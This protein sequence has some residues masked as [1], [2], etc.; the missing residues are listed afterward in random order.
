MTDRPAASRAPAGRALPRPGRDLAGAGAVGLAALVVFRLTLM[1]GPGFWDTAEAQTVPPILGTMHP[2]GFPAYVVAGWLASLLLTPVG[3]PAL[4]MN[5]F[6]ALLVAGAAAGAV[7]IARRI[8][9]PL[10][11][12]LAAGLGLALTPIAWKVA[13][14]ADAHPLHLAL[15]VLLVLLLLHWERGVADARAA[16]TP[17]AA[18]RRLVAAAAA[19]GV[20]AAN[21]SLALLVA[22]AVGLYVLATDPRVLLRPRSVLAAAGALVLVAGL[23][24]LQLPLRAGPFRAPLVYG[25]PETWDG[26][27]Y[28]VLAEQFRGSIVEPFANLDRKA[29]DLVA[30]AWAQLGPLAVLVPAGFVAVLR[31][32]PRYALLSGT[33]TAITCFFAASYQNADIGRYYLGPVLFAWTW[34]AALAAVVL[35]A[36]TGGEGEA[37][38]DG[39]ERDAPEAAAAT[40]GAS[41]LPAP[42]APLVPAAALP[43]L[44][45]AAALLVPTGTML[46]ERWRALDRSGDTRAAAWIEEAYAGLAPDAVVVSWWSYSTALWYGQLVEGRRPDVEIV[47]DRTRLDRELGEVADVIDAHLG[48]RPVYVIRVGDD[49][50]AELRT[51]YELEELTPPGGIYRVVARI[52]GSG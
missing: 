14:V 9:V 32:A 22:P 13:L 3:E 1:P 31:R 16:G 46:D 28:V 23:L 44:A 48:R 45:L 19:Y 26:F 35:E 40:P 41:T 51:R 2:T 24:Y 25:R 30:L 10:V 17:G 4:R 11:V 20:L 15:L 43:A 39:D 8:G 5:L 42:P 36:M 29:A 47:D 50:I 21:H 33:A 7:A 37:P 52:G 38:A 49:E 6:S 18:D 27:L 34:L 12:A